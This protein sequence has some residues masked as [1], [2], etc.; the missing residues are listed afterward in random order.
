[1]KNTFKINGYTDS[2]NECDRCGKTNLK[3]TYNIDTNDGNNFHLGSSCIKKAY[4]MNGK[5][6][7]NKINEDEKLRMSAAKKEFLSTKVGSFYKSYIGSEDHRLDCLNGGFKI[8]AQKI[9]GVHEL[10]KRLQ[11]KYN[12]GFINI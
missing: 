11:K 3:G 5:E 10:N 4:Q 9:R 7:T 8:V 2:H 6:L 12:V 1:M